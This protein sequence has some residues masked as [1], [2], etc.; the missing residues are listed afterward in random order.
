[1]LTIKHQHINHE[2]CQRHT[3]HNKGYE[4]VTNTSTMSFHFI[5]LSYQSQENMRMSVAYQLRDTIS[6]ATNISTFTP[7]MSKTKVCHKN[8]ICRNVIS[9][10]HQHSYQYIKEST[11]ISKPTCVEHHLMYTV[12]SF[13]CTQL[14]QF[15]LTNNLYMGHHLFNRRVFWVA[16]IRTTSTL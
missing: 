6:I 12:T 14:F 16:F 7:V 13:D 5:K 1:M 2:V 15:D 3:S 11:T 4:H 8:I 10:S 9:I